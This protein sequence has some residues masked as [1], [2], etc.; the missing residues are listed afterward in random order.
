MDKRISNKKQIMSAYK[1]KFESGCEMGKQG[2][3]VNNGAL[4][5]FFNISNALDILWVK[6]KGN[7]ISFL[8][9]N[10]LHYK[11][12]NFSENFEGGFLYTCGIDSISNCV[13]GVYMHG[14]LHLKSAENVNIVED[15]EKFI[16]TA[17]TTTSELFGKNLCLFRKYTVFSNKLVVNDTICNL[18]Y[19]SSEYVLLYH[20]NFGYPFL[21]EKMILDIPSKEIFVLKE[22]LRDKIGLC[23]NIYPPVDDNSEE[24]YYHYLNEGIINLKNTDLDISCKISYSLDDFPILWQWKSFISGDY[25]LG[26]EP[27]TTGYDKFKMCKID[28]QAEKDY[29]LTIEF[30]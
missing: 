20:I 22:K 27:S 19:K 5:V 16:I 15:D 9:K 6:Y 13:E 23:N 29:K 14:S 17:K 2:L 4:E 30:K 8:S 25:A 12:N 7:N 1:I 18:G 21:N 10:G 26:I 24:V 11:G 3:L 28:A